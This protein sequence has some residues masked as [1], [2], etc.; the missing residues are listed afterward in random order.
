M[1]WHTVLCHPVANA[2]TSQLFCSTILLEKIRNME[3][4]LC[5]EVQDEGTNSL[6]L[7]M[8]QRGSL[9]LNKH[10]GT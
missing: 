5:L 3:K 6:L 9:N 8:F 4:S 1:L 2:E 10:E 7:A